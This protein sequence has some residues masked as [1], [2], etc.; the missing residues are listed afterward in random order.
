VELSHGIQITVEPIDTTVRMEVTGD[1]GF[2]DTVTYLARDAVPRHFSLGLFAIVRNNFGATTY[3]GARIN[4][5]SQWPVLSSWEVLGSF[6]LGFDAT[7]I[8]DSRGATG[9]VVLFPL[10][11]RAGLAYRV[12]AWHIGLLVGGVA[13][14]MNAALTP[15]DAMT[16]SRV[17]VVP[18]ITAALSIRWHTSLGILGVELGAVSGSIDQAPVRG[19]LGGMQAGIGWGVSL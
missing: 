8:F 10:V 6:D 19:T 18:G 3:G 13:H 1:F 5:T 16:I 17:T 15:V 4:V 14:I 7:N 11:L 9:H 12:S 2:R